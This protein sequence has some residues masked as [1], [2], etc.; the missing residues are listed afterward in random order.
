MSGRLATMAEMRAQRLAA[1]RPGGV[2]PERARPEPAV[3][4]VVASPGIKPDVQDALEA[5]WRGVEDLGSNVVLPVSEARSSASGNRPGR[6]AVFPVFDGERLAA[7][8]YLDGQELEVCGREDL[9]RLMAL[10]RT[11]V[12]GAHRE[13]PQLPGLPPA[14]EGWESY[15]ER[16]PVK[17]IQR[18]KL[19]LLLERNEWNISRVARILGV[20]RRTVY[21]RL[22]RLGI[23]RRRV[24]KTP[25][26]TS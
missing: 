1:E 13:P 8:V 25:P 16:T 21:L 2:Q 14:A 19:T 22:R 7:L 15:L 23:A 5:V 24:A 26:P 4:T 6:L 18:Q 11:L 9:E 12:R 3:F 20:T 17:D 10:S